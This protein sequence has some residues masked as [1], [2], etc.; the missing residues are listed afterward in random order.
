M[1]A[2]LLAKIG[3]D[4]GEFSAGVK[5]VQQ[6]TKSLS[7]AFSGLGKYVAGAFSVGA[8]ATFISKVKATVDEINRAKQEADATGE[9]YQSLR[10]AMRDAGQSSESLSGILSKLRTASADARDGNMKLVGAFNSLGVSVTD[11]ESMKTDELFGAIAEAVAGAANQT[12][13]CGAVM[14]IFGNRMTAKVLPALQTV[15]EEGFDNLKGRMKDAGR[16]LDEEFTDKVNRLETRLGSLW[17]RIVGGLA[18]LSDTVDTTMK[19]LYAMKELGM[20][21]EEALRFLARA[22]MDAAEAERQAEEARRKNL[23]AMREAQKE[24]AELAEEEA[25]LAT[26]EEHL[27]EAYKAIEKSQYDA[28][29]AAQKLEAQNK[30]LAAATE[31]LAKADAEME[32]NR[33]ADT[34]EAYAQ[35]LKDYNSALDAQQKAQEAVNKEAEAAAKAS[36]NEAEA[37]DKARQKYEELAE[38]QEVAK[39]S[40]REQ[41]QWHAKT[42]GALR[43]EAAGL[44]D[45]ARKYEL[46]E[47]ALREDAEAEKLFAQAQK[48]AADAVE[49]ANRKIEQNAENIQKLAEY[50]KGL[51]PEHF[52]QLVAGLRELG[53]LAKE[54]DF[55]SF[56][57]LESLRGFGLPSSLTRSKVNQFVAAFKTLAEGLTGVKIEVPEGLDKL[58]FDLPS[59]TSGQARQFGMALQ[60]IASALRNANIDLAAVN[61]L[62]GLFDAIGAGGRA[63]IQIATPPKEDLVL[64]VEEGFKKDLSSLAKSAKTLAGLKGVIYA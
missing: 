49:D 20:G 51:S 42:A 22:E 13:A 64:T 8:I 41:A 36:A 48:E 2:K 12:E 24:A 7:D 59:I 40:T 11:L 44:Q 32:A 29:T 39:K 38:A 56:V 28:M 17:D 14:D 54:Y 6:E 34:V 16:V 47:R 46:L 19:T 57:G 3:L 21:Y 4:A 15:G 53:E 9:G 23:E 63:E 10:N 27:G 18:D 62:A 26:A 1:I 61:G 35:A 25:N 31:A 33:N 60:S 55:S 50:V 45:G 58:D 5:G 37:T 43:E 52:K 30:N